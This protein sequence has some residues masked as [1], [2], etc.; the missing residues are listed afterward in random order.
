MCRQCRCGAC[1]RFARQRVKGR[2]DAAAQLD[3]VA[4]AAACGNGK[5]ERIE[6]AAAIAEQ[7]Q[8][9]QHIGRD[10]LYESGQALRAGAVHFAEQ[11]VPD[12]AEIIFVGVA[13]R[14]H[15]SSPCREDAAQLSNEGLTTEAGSHTVDLRQAFANR[16]RA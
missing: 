5:R 16:S 10:T 15:C 2:A 7:R 9:C 13:A 11:F 4:L 8:H 12:R 3:Q 14:K 1:R 6:V